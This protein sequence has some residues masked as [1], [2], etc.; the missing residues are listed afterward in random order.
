MKEEDRIMIR[1]GMTLVSLFLAIS[2]LC[3]VSAACAEE[4][5]T[6]E[7]V[8]SVKAVFDFR[9]GNPKMAVVHMGLI[10]QTYKD[11]AAKEKNPVFAVVF[12]GPSVKLISKNREG[13]TP[14][15][16]ETLD[17]IAKT[18][19]GM[20][21]NGIELEVCLVA[22]RVLSVDPA[23]V[24]PEI[25]RVENGWVSEIAYQAKGYLMNIYTSFT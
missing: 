15:D 24:L 7:G 12:I 3:I 14:E 13:F 5:Q 9:I 25:K 16:Q 4:H 20:S 21:K 10:H 17:E 1:K 8:K 2:L 11:L 18:I 6:P 19:S 22:A 23:S